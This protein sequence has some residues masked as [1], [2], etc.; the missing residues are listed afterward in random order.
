M[1][2]FSYKTQQMR[3]FSCKTKERS[4]YDK[5]KENNSIPRFFFQE[6]SS[7]SDVIQYLA[8]DRRGISLNITLR[9]TYIGLRYSFGN[10]HLQVYKL[11]NIS[12]IVGS[13]DP[14]YHLDPFS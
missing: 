11:K 14:S 2:D 7:P 3:Y 9:E 1:R 5:K 8:V 4:L 10:L 6:F 12:W 13:V